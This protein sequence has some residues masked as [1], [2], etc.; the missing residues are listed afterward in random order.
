M[1]FSSEE[2]LQ[3][4]IARLAQQSGEPLAAGEIVVER[5][6]PRASFVAV[7]PPASSSH[8][9]SIRKRR[10]VEAT[11]EE[12]VRAGSISKA[13]SQFLEAC[14]VARGN[15]LVSGNA[16]LPLLSALAAVGGGERV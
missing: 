15:V 5:R 4:V 6:L 10:R 3:R 12:L 14:V 9:V 8:L 1:T 2:A 13:M 7:S 16:P 11:L